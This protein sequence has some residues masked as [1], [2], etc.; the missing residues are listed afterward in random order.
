MNKFLSQLYFKRINISRLIFNKTMKQNKFYFKTLVLTL[1]LSSTVLYSQESKSVKPIISIR[2]DD[3]LNGMT[4]STSIG[5]IYN[6]SNDIYTGFDMNSKGD[7]LR[8][9]MGW[10]WSSIGLGTK[11]IDAN[12]TVTIV[13]LGGS[14][15]VFDNL[16]T[17]ME[18]ILV[19]HDSVDNFLRLSF[20]VNF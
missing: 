4:P 18:Y 19:D 20:G 14:Y 10:K 2:Y 3:I 1:F 13:S 5:I 6:A 12:S 9:I 16:H 7:E 15:K 11:D 8:L 17:S